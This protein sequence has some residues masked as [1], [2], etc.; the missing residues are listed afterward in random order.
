M[1]KTLPEFIST[2][3]DSYMR[4][5]YLKFSDRTTYDVLSEL[6]TN[7]TLIKVLCG[8]YGDYGLMKWRTQ[9]LMNGTLLIF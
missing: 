5:K 9:L 6:T 7:Q 4:K 3:L 8:Q 1:Y 2:F